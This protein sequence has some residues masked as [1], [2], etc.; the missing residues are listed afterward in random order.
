MLCGL[1]D[2]TTSERRNSAVTRLGLENSETSLAAVLQLLNS[3]HV[4]RD[5]L[6]IS[7]GEANLAVVPNLLLGVQDWLRLT[8]PALE[9]HAVTSLSGD[10]RV[11]KLDGTSVVV[12][13]TRCE[14]RRGGEN[15]GAGLDAAHGDGLEVADGDDLAVLHVLERNQAVEARADGTD[16]LALVLGSVVGAG[17]VAAVDGAD[18]K[19][20]GVGVSL[21]LEDVSDTQVDLSRRERLLNSSGLGGLGLLLLLLLLFLLDARDVGSDGACNLL[22]SLLSLLTGLLGLLLNRLA[23]RGLAASGSSGLLLLLLFLLGLGVESLDGSN[24][25]VNVDG[26]LVALG[27]LQAEHWRVLNEVQVT[28]NVVVA[29]LASAL[30]GRPEL[31]DGSQAGVHADISDGG[32]AAEEGGAGREVSVQRGEALSSLR[33]VLS[34]GSDVGGGDEPLLDLSLLGLGVL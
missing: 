15:H 13:D 1:P 18:V 24:D 2:N 29:L 26:D 23:G 27:N 7:G 4:E 3:S 6:G 14:T 16:G 5:V 33:R 30:L 17:C 12:L 28:D 25:L 32:L 31:D 8:L 11:D 21:G 20:V 19:R 10:R 9:V 34:C 22:A